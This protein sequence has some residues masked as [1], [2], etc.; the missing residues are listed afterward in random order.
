MKF[1]VSILA[2]VTVV[3]APAAFANSGKGK[4]NNKAKSHKEQAVQM[5]AAVNPGRAHCPPGLAKK[6]V[7]CVPPGQLKRYGVGDYI[8][9]NYSILNDPRRWGLRSNGYYVQAGG[10]VYEVS[11]ETNQVFNLIGAV[12]DILN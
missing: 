11:R 12:A 6:A 8:Y 7:P 9:D 3:T 1:L 2:V 4:G 10:Y 5:P